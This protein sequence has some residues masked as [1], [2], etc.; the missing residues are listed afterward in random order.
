MVFILSFAFCTF[1]LVCSHSQH[2]FY[3]NLFN[4]KVLASPK[5]VSTVHKSPPP[6]QP[7]TQDNEES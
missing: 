7:I 2:F 1:L 3:Q 4:V 5:M 6:I